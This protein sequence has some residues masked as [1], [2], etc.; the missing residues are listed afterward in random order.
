MRCHLKFRNRG[1]STNFRDMDP[2]LRKGIQQKG[3]IAKERKRDERVKEWLQFN[4]AE[5]WRYRKTNQKGRIPQLI[6]IEIAYYKQHRQWLPLPYND[7]V[8]LT[9]RFDQ[10]CPFPIEK[11]TGAPFG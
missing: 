1:D 9:K 7:W 11:N 10:S 2:A 8:F 3:R 4:A 6:D 5:L